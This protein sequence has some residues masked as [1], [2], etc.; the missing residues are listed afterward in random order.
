[1]W[2]FEVTDSMRPGVR[3]VLTPGRMGIPLGIDEQFRTPSTLPVGRSISRVLDHP[4]DQVENFILKRGTLQPTATG[5]IVVK[6]TEEEAIAER[7]ALVFV[8]RCTDKELGYTRVTEAWGRPSPNLIFGTNG[9][10]YRREL[11]EFKQGDAL[12]ICWPAAALD[13]V[14]PKRFIIF[15]DGQQLTEELCR[16]HPKRRRA[17]RLQ[18]ASVTEQPQLQEAQSS[19]RQARQQQEQQLTP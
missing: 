11:Y 18:K 9:Q 17:R 14:H 13:Q 12:F 2:L 8:D 15:W 3:L 5:F 10:G 1:M 6:Q 4:D 16:R 19:P 7:K